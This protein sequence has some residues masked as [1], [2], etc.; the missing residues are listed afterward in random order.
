MQ[1]ND[2]TVLTFNP[3]FSFTYRRNTL[4]PAAADCAAVGALNKV[5][6]FGG[7]LFKSIGNPSEGERKEDLNGKIAF[8]LPVI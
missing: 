3:L 8:P 7:I 5:L 2:K 4:S 6:L 1:E